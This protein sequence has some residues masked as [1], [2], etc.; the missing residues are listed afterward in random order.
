MYSGNTELF[1]RRNWEWKILKETSQR[2]KIPSYNLIIWT[3]VVFK[4]GQKNYTY[5]CGVAY[6]FSIMLLYIQDLNKN[7]IV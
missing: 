4:T 6:V 3:D 5:L 2:K 1:K 7:Y